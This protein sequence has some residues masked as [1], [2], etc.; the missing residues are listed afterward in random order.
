M[1]EKMEPEEY[2]EPEVKAD[3]FASLKTVTPLSKYLAM[4]LF[5][6]LPFVGGYVGYL[7]GVSQVEEMNINSGKNRETKEIF[8][9]Q[10][11]SAELDQTDEAL[12]VSFI[13]SYEYPETYAGGKLPLTIDFGDGTSDSINDATQYTYSVPGVYEVKLRGCNPKVDL[14][15]D[16]VDIDS[17]VVSVGV[18]D[19]SAEL[20]REFN[21][22]TKIVGDLNK[23][24]V[25]TTTIDM[26]E[27]RIDM[28]KMSWMCVFEH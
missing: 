3:R 2:N 27:Y 25:S 28:T 19:D 21:Q 8:S 24:R 7:V 23:G 4:V 15:C 26:G 10:Y 1:I 20:Q 12:T 14:F 18:T 17:L 13:S 5:I 9:S 22:E 11:L 6:V 16:Q